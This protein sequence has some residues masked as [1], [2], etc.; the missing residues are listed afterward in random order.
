MFF[1]TGVGIGFVCGVAF[2]VSGVTFLHFIE[3]M[4]D[5]PSRDGHAVW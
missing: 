4:A 2:L 5:S 1:W 3:M